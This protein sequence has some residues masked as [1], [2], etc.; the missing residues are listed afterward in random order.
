MA[1]TFMGPISSHICSWVDS[2]AY[3]FEFALFGDCLHLLL[4]QFDLGDSVLVALLPVDALELGSRFV[5]LLLLRLL[6][7]HRY[8]NSER[9]IPMEF[10]RPLAMEIRN[11]YKL[12]KDAHLKRFSIP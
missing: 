2:N 4:E 9:A 1:R 5:L 10:S 11:S 6:L 12:C 3:S 8:Y 7:L